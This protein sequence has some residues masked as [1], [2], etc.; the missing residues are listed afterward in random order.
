MCERQRDYD[1]LLKTMDNCIKKI[2][3]QEIAFQK[4]IILGSNLPSKLA[5]MLERCKSYNS[6]F[7]CFYIGQER[8]L[9]NINDSLRKHI[10]FISWNAP[11]GKE[12]AEYLEERQ[13][14]NQ[15][16]GMIFLGASHKNLRDTNILTLQALLT[17]RFGINSY[18]YN[19]NFEEVYEYK[20]IE[21]Y[22]AGIEAYLK[23]NNFFEKLH[24]SKLGE[25]NK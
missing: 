2:P 10:S 7:S 17:G 8:Q 15:C 1:F 22:L 9:E 3:I 14:L 4:L 11:Y 12:M 16:D 24:A 5:Y 6:D 20:D 13:V 18:I 19:Y 21:L 23:M 25:E